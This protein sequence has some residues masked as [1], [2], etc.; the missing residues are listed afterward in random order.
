[1]A[2]RNVHHPWKDALA[3]FALLFLNIVF[4]WKILLTNLILV[5]L[6]IFTYFYP[7]REY[8][9]EAWREGHIPLWNPYLFMGVPFLA[10]IQA[11][12]LYPINVALAWLPAPQSVNLSIVLH[13]FLAA[14]FTYLF[15]R[16][17]LGLDPLGGF[18]AASC[19]AL[20]GYLGAQAEHVNQLNVTVWFPLL[21]L[22][23]DAAWDTS[24]LRPGGSAALEREATTA[25]AA[26]LCAALA[27]SLV[28]ALQILAGHT[29]AV[30]ITLSGA[31]FYAVAPLLLKLL[32]RADAGGL[33]RSSRLWISDNSPR[34]VSWAGL[35]LA[36]LAGSATVG[37][38]LSAVQLLP[39]LELTGLSFRSSGLPYREAVSFSLR[40]QWLLQSLLPPYQLDMSQIFGAS[41]SE[42]VVYIGVIGLLLAIIGWLWG[43]S[44]HRHVFGLLGLVGVFLGLGGYNPFYYLLYRLAPGFAMFRAPVRWMALYSFAVSILVGYGVQ[45]LFSQDCIPRIRTSVGALIHRVKSSRRTLIAVMAIIAITAFVMYFLDFP[46]TATVV[47]WTICFLAGL[48]I[49]GAIAFQRLSRRLGQAV[50]TAALIAELFIASR[51]LA[52]NN[53]TA[54]QAFDFL[55]PAPAFLLTDPGEHRFISMSG[56][57]YDPGDLKEITDIYGWQLPERAVYDYVV[58]VKQKEVLAFNLPLHYR[59]YVVDGYDGGLLPLKRFVKLQ[60]LFLPKDAVSSD[61]RLRE[62]LKEVP[63][64]RLLSLLNV[65][66]VIT[67]KVYDVWID[68]VFYDLQ[69]TARL[70][71]GLAQT[72]QTQ[73]ILPEAATAIGVI[74]HLLGATTVPDDTPVA[75]LVVTDE[76]G[77]QTHHLLRAGRDTA[78]GEYGQDGPVKHAKARVGH[79]W[80]D[81]PNGNDYVAVFDFDRPRVI[82]DITLRNLLTQ[83]EF[84]LRGVSLIDRRTVSNRTVLL[85]TSG[86]FRLVYSGDVKIYENLDNL[87][88]AFIVHHARVMNDDAEIV[89]AMRDP[90]FAPASTVILSP[91]PRA[92]A[93]SVASDAMTTRPQEATGE[94]SVTIVSYFP[95]HVVLDVETSVAG[96][97]VLTDTD[98][99]G[100]EATIDGRRV[101]IYRA[102]LTCR[103]IELPAGRHR[104]EFHYKPHMFYVG[105]VISLISLL[106]VLGGL[107]WS[108]IRGQ[109]RWIHFCQDKNS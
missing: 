22:L 8:A 96:Y 97:L 72:V 99:P 16:R 12:V 36:W 104:I 41:F 90:S 76:A 13:V 26:R 25:W 7:Y 52:Y 67:D 89:A 24:Y 27:A 56:I 107:I 69:F 83:G 106:A 19:F 60:E 51:G 82:K 40:P 45:V 91:P 18:L 68:D 33:A 98:Y 64:S 85:S 63:N 17:S 6:D 39:T 5:G 75:E 49:V 94:D 46:E 59:L 81:N 3:V 20:G 66:Y 74:S 38:L 54:P 73:D 62:Q 32:M 103:A 92:G 10:N 11:A 87:P 55:R 47:L 4:F 43:Y 77:G 28:I 84:D 1:M 86:R 31:A 78:E 9:A 30:F 79:R 57:T 50:L 95:E 35:R 34:C 42:Y 102:N 14:L 93:E 108:A 100:W 80:R 15:V 37:G 58:C 48:I 61:G 88:R 70:G 23:M 29:Q 2:E 101:P 44:P 71:P 53:P 105:A 109:R 21:L 65:K